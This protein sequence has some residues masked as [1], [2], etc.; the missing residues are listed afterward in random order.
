MDSVD[1]Y[2]GYMHFSV[3]STKQHE[4]PAALH[5]LALAHFTDKK[6]DLHL[7]L[8]SVQ[9]VNRLSVYINFTSMFTRKLV[10]I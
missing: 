9:P 6:N 1:Y 4:H 7:R 2:S 10:H 5:L 3:R 8:S